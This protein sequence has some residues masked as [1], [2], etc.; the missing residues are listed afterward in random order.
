MMNDRSLPWL[1]GGT[2]F[3]GHDTAGLRE[4]Q[5]SRTVIA[6]I[7]SPKGRC[8]IFD[9]PRSARDGY[10]RAGESVHEFMEFSNG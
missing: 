4:W 5:I 9:S 7:R 8:L 2:K 6:E 10:Q 1:V 3:V